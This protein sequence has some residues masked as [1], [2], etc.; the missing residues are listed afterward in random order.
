MTR[1]GF[2]FAATCAMCGK[3]HFAGSLQ[4]CTVQPLMRQPVSPITMIRCGAKSGR[5]KACPKI[6]A[7][8][9]PFGSVTAHSRFANC[10]VDGARRRIGVFARSITASGHLA[11]CTTARASDHPPGAI[12]TQLDK[13]NDPSARAGGGGGG[14]VNE[15]EA[16]EK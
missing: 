12:W 9:A 8:R 14:G 11:P 6:E 4:A 3:G 2:N 1:S 16:T 13:S 10:G 15:K 7:F 5:G